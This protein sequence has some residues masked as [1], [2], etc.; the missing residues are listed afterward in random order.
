MSIPPRGDYQVLCYEMVAVGSGSLQ[1][2]FE[3]IKLKLQKE[4]LFDKKRKRPLPAFPKHIAL[5]TSPTGAAVRDILQVL[6]RRFKAI[7]ITLIPAF[8]QGD[9]APDS[10]LKALFM[11]KKIPADVLIIARGGGS[12]EDLQA[13]NHEALA[14]AIFDHPVPVISAVGH[15]IDFTICDFVSD[16]R[17]PTPSAGAEMVAQNATELL[18]TIQRMEKQLVQNIILKFR[19]LKDKILS[20][21]KALVRPGRLL[22]D[23]SQKLD[24]VSLNLERNT[25]NLLKKMQD[26]LSQFEQILISLNPKEVMKRGFSIV[27][28]PKGDIVCNTSQ[29]KLKD[30]L[31]IH[32]F[33]GQA[34]TIV[35]EKE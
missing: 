21:D 14:R 19:F 13:F 22:Q 2:Q 29:F 25:Q 33:K 24:G 5:I 16:L 27:T 26:Q 7:K 23:A 30:F 1:Q 20:I 4:G 32:F 35:T 8:V 17:A 18:D 6:N 31:N 10:L 12:I 9:K 34:K 11:A 28:D 15:E 3:E